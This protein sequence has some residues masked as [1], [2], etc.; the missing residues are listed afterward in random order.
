[1]DFEN[2]F[3]C[4][5]EVDDFEIGEKDYSKVTEVKIAFENEVDSSVGFQKDH[6]DDEVAI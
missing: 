6:V 2:S 5:I 3:T 1:M 4:S